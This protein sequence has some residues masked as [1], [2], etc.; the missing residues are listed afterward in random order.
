MHCLVANPR[1]TSL[2][3]SLVMP[4]GTQIQVVRLNSIGG[5]LV[6][7]RISYGHCAKCRNSL[8]LSISLYLSHSSAETRFSN[9]LYFFWEKRLMPHARQRVLH[10]PSKGHHHGLPKIKDGIIVWSRNS[11]HWVSSDWRLH[12]AGRK[13]KGKSNKSNQHVPKFCPIVRLETRKHAASQVCFIDLARYLITPCITLQMYCQQT[14]HSFH[15][16]LVWQVTDHGH[17]MPTVRID[18]IFSEKFVFI[19]GRITWVH[20]WMTR[21]TIPRRDLAPTGCHYILKEIKAKWWQQWLRVVESDATMASTMRRGYDC[22]PLKSFADHHPKSE[23][24]LL[25]ACG[26]CLKSNPAKNLMVYHHFPHDLVSFEGRILAVNHCTPT[27]WGTMGKKQPLKAKSDPASSQSQES[28]F[29]L[30]ISGQRIQNLNGLLPW[31][32]LG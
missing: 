4:W 24:K 23:W 18:Q 9:A 17:Q 15:L 19:H 20:D 12:N 25:E 2:T 5:L 7:E 21:L 8:S 28:I 27:I 13:C 16:R 31:L 6:L 22:W 32:G 29:V 26:L 30:Q 3:K 14:P 10:W 1:V 11:L